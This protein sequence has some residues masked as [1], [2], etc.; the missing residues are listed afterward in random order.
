VFPGGYNYR[1]WRLR[2]RGGIDQVI[3]ALLHITVQ[4]PS[5]DLKEF[6]R[7]SNKI[8]DKR[9]QCQR[10]QIEIRLAYRLVGLRPGD[11][12]NS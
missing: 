7:L 6:A 5:H 12:G 3:F 1:G 2:C 4:F 8:G 11:A 9:Q 10:W